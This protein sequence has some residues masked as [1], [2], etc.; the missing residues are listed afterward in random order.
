MKEKLSIYL[1]ELNLQMHE[2]IP[3]LKIDHLV[4]QADGSL[5]SQHVHV[6]GHTERLLLKHT[7]R[8]VT[9]TTRYLSP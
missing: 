2:V 1:T 8:H 4:C 6:D 5:G 9:H 3:Y 7:C